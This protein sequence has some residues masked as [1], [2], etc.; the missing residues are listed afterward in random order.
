MPEEQ[1]NEA[2]SAINDAEMDGK[3]EKLLSEHPKIKL[4][5]SS[6]LRNILDNH[7]IH[8]YQKLLGNLKELKGMMMVEDRDRKIDEMMDHFSSEYN[9]AAKRHNERIKK[10][11]SHFGKKPADED[12]ANDNYNQNEGKE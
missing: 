10:T 9:K 3:L 7:I 11:N 1:K 6:Y 8:N 2:E 5:I 12:I 4:Y